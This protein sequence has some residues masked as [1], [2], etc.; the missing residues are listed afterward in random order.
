M[1]TIAKASFVAAIAAW[2]TTSAAADAISA[3]PDPVG[4]YGGAPVEACAWPTTVFVNDCTG[5]L[6][7]P[8]VV[9]LAAHCVVFGG[10]AQE[11]AFGENHNQ[12]ARTV[13][14]DSCT[15][16]PDW[17][18][19][20]PGDNA[21]DIAICQLSAPVEDVPIVPILMGCETDALA[22]GT[23]VTLVGFGDAD[24]AF[25]YG[26]KRSVVTQIQQVGTDAVWIGGDG[27]SSCYGDSGGPAYVQLADGSWRVFGAT[28][29]STTDDPGCGQTSIWTLVHPYAG[30]IESTAGVDVTPCH[31]ADGTWNPSDACQAFPMSPGTGGATW[32]DGCEG[33]RSGI[34]ET[35]GAGFGGGTT[36]GDD[37][38]GELG[39]SDDDAAPAD[40]SS[41]GANN[42]T[43]SEGAADDTTSAEP[44]TEVGT[45]PGPDQ[46]D[47]DVDAG[48]GCATAPSG[49]RG[50]LF[51]LIAFA[52]LKS[53]R[54]SAP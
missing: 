1:T 37:G 2:P 8:R 46:L 48:C 19:V 21:S 40:E 9:V 51:V 52:T 38:T 29:G 45:E 28:S 22:A 17:Q 43:T 15:A 14:V 42:G 39:S 49:T 20:P 13:A 24:D 7:H 26:P 18:D 11:V 34:A 47:D 54:R 36:T 33:E 44:S 4:I 23:S 53:R 5:T 3:P 12:P 6:V 30:W 16:H 50:S 35:C 10:Q 25:G 32:V 31:D 41:T 27:A